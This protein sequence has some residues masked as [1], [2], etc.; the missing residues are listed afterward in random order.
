VFAH[1]PNTLYRIDPTTLSL[2]TVGTLSCDGGAVIDIAL[3][4]NGEMF[5]TTFG[6]LVKINKQS[7]ACTTIKTGS[8]PNSLSFV[9]A[10]TVHP[11]TEA[12]VG[13]LGAQYVEIDTVTGSV[14]TIGD[15]NGSGLASSGDIVSVINGGT[16]L[17]VNGNSCADCLV[18]VDPTTGA[19]LNNF[20]PIGYSSVY[21]LAF[22]GGV[23]YGFDGFGNVFS[24]DVATNATALV[25]VTGASSYYGAGSSTCVPPVKQQ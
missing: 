3:N 16:Y 11:N 9:P 18:Q 8:Y 25:Q 2:T 19:L 17:T 24:Y 13:Y 20:G 22:W 12:L 23:V 14:T 7:A 6:A 10:G 1:G 15:L 5:G 21:G 4:K